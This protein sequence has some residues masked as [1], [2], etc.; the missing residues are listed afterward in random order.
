MVMAVLEVAVVVM[1]V[2][3]AAEVV[4]PNGLPRGSDVKKQRRQWRGER[5]L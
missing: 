2:V 4:I 3:M 1:V 5:R